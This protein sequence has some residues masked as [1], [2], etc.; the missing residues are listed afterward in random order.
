MKGGWKTG[1]CTWPSASTWKA[2]KTCLAYGRAATRA[3]S[4]GWGA[5]GVEEPRGE[6]R[7]DRLHRRAEGVSAGDRGDLSRGAGAVV[8][9]A[10]GAGQSELCQLERTQ[11][12]GGRSEVDLPGGQRAPSGQ[13]VGGVRRQVGRQI[14]GDRETLERKLGAYQSVV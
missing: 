1:R 6:G 9:C 12:G 2:V 5:D 13:R 7:S 4:S 3:P 11:A 14:S 10:H 8:Y